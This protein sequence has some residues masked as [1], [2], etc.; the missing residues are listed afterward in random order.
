[1]MPSNPKFLLS[2]IITLLASLNLQ[3]QKLVFADTAELFMPNLVSTKN[4]DVKIT[5]SPDGNKMLWG[6]IDWIEGKTD[7]DIWQSDR[8]MVRCKK[9]ERVGF[10]TDYNDF[11][12]YF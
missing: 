1:M 11:D 2:C 8:I 10:D 4:A 3:A 5:F 6:G 12:H 7:Q 9:H